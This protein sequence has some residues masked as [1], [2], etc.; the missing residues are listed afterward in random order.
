M[1]GIWMVRNR[2]IVFNLVW[3]LALA[4]ALNAQ[5]K[6]RTQSPSSEAL[7]DTI[8]FDADQDSLLPVKVK[9]R[10]DDSL[11]R[12]SRWLPKAKRVPA[13]ESNAA[14]GAAT[15]GTATG[16][17]WFGTGLSIGNMLGWLL[18]FTLLTAAVMA[19]AYALSRSEFEFSASRS[20]RTSKRLDT[21]DQQT[22][23]RMKHLPAELRR[24]D[25]NLKSEA[26]RLMA[27]QNFDQAIILLFAHQLLLL[28]RGGLLRLNRGKTNRRYVRETRSA[29]RET[30][31]RLQATINAFE[32]SY[33]GR[34]TINAQ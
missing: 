25:V 13:P 17:G 6:A 30:A 33:F 19:I 20:A 24:T 32:R 23:E 1:Q 14:T 21:P 8:W 27:E 10:E 3:L 5:E 18:L 29:D 26:A 15:G 28:D 9:P 31:E 16:G 34:H 12:D 7:S 2:R 22:L 4:P 11:N